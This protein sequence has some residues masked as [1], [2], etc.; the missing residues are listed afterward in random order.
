MIKIF[1]YPSDTKSGVWYYRSHLPLND[2]CND[3]EFKCMINNKIQF[4]EDDARYV[5]ANF[6]IFYCH[7]GLY[8]ADAQDRFWKFIVA[9]KEG[10]VKTVI[11]LDDYW[12]YGP[13]HP[14]D[15]IC[16]MNAF[17]QKMQINLKLF[18]YVTTTTERF[19]KKIM[20]YTGKDNVF[21]FENA[22]SRNEEQFSTKKNKSDKVRVAIAGSSSHINDI[23]EMQ[24]FPKFL[25][26]ETMGKIEFVF[27]GYDTNAVKKFIDENGKVV[28]QESIELKDNWWEQMHQHWLKHFGPEHYKCVPSK[29][30]ND[31]EY[32]KIYEDIDVLL[33][34][35]EATEFNS[36][37]SELKFIEAG[38]TDTAV[39]AQST[40]PYS[41]YGI[42]KEDCLLVKEHTAR[43]WAIKVM[44]IVK[45]NA[46]RKK[47]TENLSKRVLKERCLEDITEKR[48][49]FFKEII[50]N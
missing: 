6:D 44:K 14:L 48:K 24:E 7:N 18:D 35:L 4:S 36:C 20:K 30:I 1:Y 42:D 39:I 26:K 38:F 19:A 31:G 32:G 22:I 12:D 37:K 2:L 27:C 11:D 49:K 17:P 45:D 15:N 23:K 8:M 33:V 21:I 40:P 50:K 47:I 46:L 34:P 28:K 9:L 16:Q 13:S 43:A 5:I 3:P 25:D 29:S 10:G 41:D